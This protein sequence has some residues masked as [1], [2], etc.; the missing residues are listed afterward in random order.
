MTGRIDAS[1]SAGAAA[2]PP[3]EP[4]ITARVGCHPFGRR[5]FGCSSAPNPTIALNGGTLP[6]S[7]SALC[8][9][10]GDLDSSEFLNSGVLTD[11]H[12]PWLG[13]V[14]AIPE[15]WPLANVFSIGDVLV[16]AGVGWAAHRICGSRLAPR[17]SA[18]PDRGSARQPRA[19]HGLRSARSDL[20]A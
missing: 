9:A 16:L 5:A 8:T 10:G 6:A 7:P 11:P 1:S 18:R 2:S 3:A 12:L 19:R 20:R 4:T 17:W 14:F 15:G 13:D